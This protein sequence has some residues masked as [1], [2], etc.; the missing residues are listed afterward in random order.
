MSL[1]IEAKPL[2]SV[3]DLNSL[4][5]ISLKFTPDDPVQRHRLARALRCKEEKEREKEGKAI[6]NGNG[7]LAKTKL[8][9]YGGQVLI[10]FGKLEE[11]LG[12]ATTRAILL[13]LLPSIA[14]ISP[15]LPSASIPTHGPFLT[16]HSG[17]GC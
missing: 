3:P 5:A 10:K 15:C 9:F 11:N 2:S 17:I 16:F 6:G 8:D 14:R 13:L 12:V 1:N 4:P 7:Y